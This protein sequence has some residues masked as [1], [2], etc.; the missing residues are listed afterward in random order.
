MSDHKSD[1]EIQAEREDPHTKS[2]I[3]MPAA[4]DA[5][6][7]DRVTVNFPAEVPSVLNDEKSITLKSKL[8]VAKR[9]ALVGMM[10]LPANPEEHDDAA[11]RA[12]LIDEFVEMIREAEGEKLDHLAPE[13]VQKHFGV[14]AHG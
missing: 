7:L 14:G 1:A 9:Q 10:I 6:L 13:R 2:L 11:E 12:E 4:N 3:I 8:D 5:Y